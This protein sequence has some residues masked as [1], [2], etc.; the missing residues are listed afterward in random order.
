MNKA[1][2]AVLVV[3]GAFA[4]SMTAQAGTFPL[5]PPVD[6][7]IERH[8]D[9]PAS[10]WGA[11]HRGIDYAV[12][13]GEV[14]RAAGAGTVSFAGAVAGG[15]VVS[16]DHGAGLK[17]TYSILTRV[18]VTTGDEVAEGQF[19]GVTGKAHPGA[20]D[21]LH[22]GVKL[23]GDYVDPVLY[24]GRLDVSG[25]IHLAPLSESLLDELPYELT[26]AHE[27]AGAAVRGCRDPAELEVSPPPPSD[28]V[29][30]AVAGLGSHTSGSSEAF[31]YD[32]RHGP[33][34]LGYPDERVY[35]FSY[36]GVDLD[37]LH[38][39]YERA[40]TYRALARSARRFK[41]LLLAIGRKHPGAGVDVFA[42]SQGGL[43]ARVALSFGV[44]SF[45]PRVPRIEHLVT[46][47][48]PHEGT[49][50][51]QVVADLEDRTLFGSKL[52]DALAEWSANGGPV[53]NPRARSL[54][55]MEPDAD[56]IAGL[57]GEDVTF[58][59]RVLALAM[60]HDGIV[61]ASSAAIEGEHF[62]ILRPEGLNGH[63]AVVSSE[64]GRALA[65]AF[66][67]D[68]APSCRGAWD[69][70]GPVMGRTVGALQKGL[71]DVWSEIESLGVSGAARAGWWAARRGWALTRWSAGRVGDGLRW[72]GDRAV[73]GGRA[74]VSAGRW[75]GSKVVDGGRLI[76][77]G[78][79]RLWGELRDL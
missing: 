11:G 37:S 27:G 17:S 78:V 14:V 5:S 48:T 3:C 71:D 52:V 1:I 43:V 30:I 15:L 21:D 58:G 35:R 63:V 28:N 32:R 54:H 65:Y 44:G 46:Y 33:W 40:A 66:V 49:P 42:H 29:A 75:A 34:A 45:D 13:S 56:L 4:S 62:R 60:P 6:A 76:H 23:D 72:A 20:F 10:A 64:E 74:L 36:D 12:A 38:E 57:R 68:A 59:T 22:F 53:P 69:K 24:L 55:D 79:A 77:N 39:P 9:A 61:P 50:L 25:A 8:Y 31:I 47:G 2:A 41:D 51:A 7:P 73:D 19:I 70:W 67:R 18:D 16:I 26:A